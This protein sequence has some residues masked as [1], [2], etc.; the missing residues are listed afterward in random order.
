MSTVTTPRLSP[1]ITALVTEATER[2][3]T[4]DRLNRQRRQHLREAEYPRDVASVAGWI[5]QNADA[6]LRL[7]WSR[8]RSLV[9]VA[10][11]SVIA[12]AEAAETA[13]TLRTT[14]DALTP[15]TTAPAQDYA[16]VQA[17]E[18]ATVDAEAIREALAALTVA[19]DEGDLVSPLHEQY[20]KD[21]IVAALVVDRNVKQRRIGAIMERARRDITAVLDTQHEHAGLR[22]WAAGRGAVILVEPLEP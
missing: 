4:L 19:I 8:V 17:R 5:A 11:Q 16:T 15:P 2:T 9:G 6:L 1:S 12:R 18:Q 21:V 22:Q 7:L 10:E 14:L 13:A 3:T 20:V